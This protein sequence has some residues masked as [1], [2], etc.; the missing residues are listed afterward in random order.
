MAAFSIATMPSLIAVGCA[1]A[2]LAHHWRKAART[3]AVPLQ[4]LNAALLVFLALGGSGG[5]SG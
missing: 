3:L 5:I 1:G 4:G 2:G